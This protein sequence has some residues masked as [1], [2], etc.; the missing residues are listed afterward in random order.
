MD[1]AQL[2]RFLDTVW[3]YY[4]AHGRHDLPWRLPE[5]DGTFDP[6]KILVSE[7]MLQ[8]TQV[9]RVLPK[10]HAFLEHFPTVATL[11]Q[12]RLGDVLIAWSGLGYNRRAKYLWQAAQLVA[13]DF[14]GTFPQSI[15][16]L[17]RLPGVGQNTAG[18]MVTYAFNQPAVFIET[19]V[20]TVL[21]YHFFKQRTDIHDAEIR[22][23][24]ER[25]FALENDIDYRQFYWALM[26]YGTYLKQTVGNLSR[27]SRAY[28][29]QPPFHGSQRQLR[30][31]V[32][33]LLAHKPL[34]SA[35]LLATLPDQ[36]TPQV[37]ADLTAEHMI[38]KAAN[39]YELA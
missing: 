27:A 38:I 4:T 28:A 21:I 9:Q 31:Q 36:R 8:Q 33:K 25:I 29:K 14:D 2:Q 17:V 13:A 10:Y 23:I 16:E 1:T 7:L 18:A 32:L 20:R 24:L 6:Y 22:E 12:A 5:P 3:N 26:D 11:A 30:G 37:L 19:N 34:S 35:E 15:D 39:I